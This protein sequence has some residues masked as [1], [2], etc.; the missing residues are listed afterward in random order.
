[1]DDK[2]TTTTGM[3]AASSLFATDIFDT[4]PVPQPATPEPAPL[5]TKAEQDIY[6]HLSPQEKGQLTAMVKSMDVS[7][8]NFTSEYGQDVR[9][10]IVKVNDKALQVTRTKDLGKVGTSMANLMSQLKGIELPE[11]SRGLFGRARSYIDQLNSKLAPVEANVQKA[12]RI[13]ETHKMQLA[14]D[15]D[16]YDVLYKQN[17]AHY[18]ALSLYIIAGKLKLDEERKTTLEA[19]RK[20]ATQ[21]GDMADAEAFSAYKSVLNQFDSLLG[22]FESSRLLCLQTAPAIRIAQENNKLLIQKFDYIFATAVPAWR[23]Q[24]HLALNQENSRQAA[25]AANAA[26]DFTNDLIRQNADSLKQSTIDVARLSEREIIE[27]DTLEYANQRL[28]EG[29][30]AIFEIH[31]EGQARRNESRVKRAMLEEDLKNE[32]LQLTTRSQSQQ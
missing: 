30:D 10:G 9:M 1:M 32:L 26:I 15:N 23:T 31:E 27:S 5:L 20:K 3:G 12:V 19:L 22:E 4:A 28:I 7:A 21:S 24:I 16:E 14:A 18:R 2:K 6:D 25:N 17:L 29:L 11:Q 13:M 8:P